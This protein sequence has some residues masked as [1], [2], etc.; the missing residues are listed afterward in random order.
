[1]KKILFGITGLTL[2]GA[3]RVLVDI[4]NKLVE[5]YDIT[6]FTIYGNGELE[7]ALDSKVKRKTIFSKKYQELSRK[8]KIKISFQILFQKRKLYNKYIKENYDIEIAFL[9]GPIT[10]LFAVKNEKVRKI[11]WIHNDI[12]YVFGSGWKSKIKKWIDKKSYTFYQKLI[13]VSQDNLE[14]FNNYYNVPVPKQVIYNYISRENVEGKAK[15]EISIKFDKDKINLVS[16]SRLVEQKGIDRWIRVHSKLKKNGSNHVVYIIGDGPLK[17]RLE[18]QI[19][20]EGIQDSFFLL[21]QLKNPYP[22]INCSDYFCLFSYFE[23]YGMVLE[24]AKI[25]N[26]AIL[27]TNTAAREAVSGY[28]NAMIFENSEEG[29]ETGL[30]SITKKI[31]NRVECLYENEERLVEIK[32]LLEEK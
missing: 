6:I 19:Q 15:E 27:I 20:E 3:E 21:G 1:M 13:F 11:A 9:E 26:K 23:G 14:K 25:L 7:T 30:R 31:E 2:G 18:K 22:F 4:A 16:V 32:R 5:D 8:E 17:G 12:S 10:R 28:D 29:L 24:E